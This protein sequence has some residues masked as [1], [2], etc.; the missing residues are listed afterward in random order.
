MFDLLFDAVL[1]GMVP[2][3]HGL[4]TL[5]LLRTAAPGSWGRAGCINVQAVATAFIRANLL[6]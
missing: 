5:C 3:L 2:R 4:R 1:C 6:E